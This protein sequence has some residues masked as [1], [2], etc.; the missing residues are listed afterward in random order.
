MSWAIQVAEAVSSKL[1]MRVMRVSQVVSGSL[2]Q[3]IDSVEV[4]VDA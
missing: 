2:A 3:G 4:T 1:K